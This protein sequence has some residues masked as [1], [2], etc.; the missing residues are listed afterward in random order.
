M[1]MPSK[2][3]LN[4]PKEKQEKLLIAAK[5]EFTR[6]SYYEAS[7]NKMIQDAKISRG[8][9]YMYFKDKEDLYFYL[10]TTVRNDI[11]H[12]IERAL[13]K[14]NGL[15]GISF[16]TFF[17]DLIDY[18]HKEENGLYLKNI[19]SNLDFKRGKRLFSE[20]EDIT[21]RE[22]VQKVLNQIDTSNLKI[23]NQNELI[24]V[25]GLFFQLIHQSIIP[26][27]LQDVDRS[28]MKEKL[29]RKVFLLEHGINK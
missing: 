4:L 10:L 23:E 9:F 28:M 13:E 6:T 18:C 2:T 11:F 1:P 7:I 15:L 25:L 26:V 29:K 22:R 20:Q 17:D 27:M 8:S 16:L 12:L 3:F 21:F 24:E 14:N 19:F 5:K